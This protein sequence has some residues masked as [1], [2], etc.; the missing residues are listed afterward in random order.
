ML[1]MSMIWNL[2][3]SVMDYDWASQMEAGLHGRGDGWQS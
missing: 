1:F 2:L 3:E